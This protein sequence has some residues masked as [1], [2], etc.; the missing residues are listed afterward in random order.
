MLSNKETPEP[1]EELEFRLIPKF[2]KLLE[3]Y[4]ETDSQIS[5]F[6]IIDYSRPLNPNQ[7]LM[8]E[9][10]DVLN[11]H[12]KII[13]K[14]KKYVINKNLT[15]KFIPLYKRAPK[16]YIYGAID[17]DSGG[18][19]VQNVYD[20]LVYAVEDKIKKVKPYLK[21][22]SHWW[23]ILVDYISPGLEQMDI[24]Q[25]K[26]IFDVDHFF[27]RMVII[28]PESPNTGIIL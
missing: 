2:K 28:T 3:K 20:G 19:V 11:S 6:V 13:D 18:M 8:S 9:I 22:Y 21:K 24:D 15:L 17:G 14:S 7:K 4:S 1:H 26:E 10:E 16:T 27:E 12:L 25:L 23:L 5:S